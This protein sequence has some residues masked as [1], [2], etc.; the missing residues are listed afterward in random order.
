[1]RAL[2]VAGLCTFV[3]GADQGSDESLEA[4]R[5]RIDALSAIDKEELRRKKERF[6]RLND[7]EK[8]RLRALHDEICCDSEGNR[9]RQVMLRYHEWLASLPS[10][11]RAELMSLPT[12]QRLVEIRNLLKQQERRRFEEFV[13]KTLQ[14]DDYETILEWFNAAVNQNETRLAA[15]LPPD[16]RER[17]QMQSDPRRRRFEL[18]RLLRRY[19]GERVEGTFALLAFEEKAINDLAARVSGEARQALDKAADA[20]SRNRVVNNWIRAA[21]F[22]KFV[23][24]VSDE[25]LQTF[26]REQVTKSQRDYL[27]DLPREVMLREL[28]RMYFAHHFQGRFGGFGDGGRRG[29]R[30]GGRGGEFRPPIGPS[31]PPGRSD[32]GHDMRGGLPHQERPPGERGKSPD[33]DNRVRS[34]EH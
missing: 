16:E 25:E 22:S 27:D 3:L 17:L 12:E 1:V 13:V 34:Q 10:A 29:G 14:P 28:Q 19:E 32:R 2:L 31:G 4:R 9:L 24:R 7:A 21:I 15:N 33:Q 30:G 26:L 5:Q 8:Q 20:E 6:D 18:M 11:R 23:P